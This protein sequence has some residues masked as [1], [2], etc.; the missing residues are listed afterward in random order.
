MKKVLKTISIALILYSF[1]LSFYGCNSFTRPPSKEA[2]T[3]V[4]LFSNTDFNN[5]GL[6]PQK[7]FIKKDLSG[8]IAFSVQGKEED[9]TDV[10]INAV[11]EVNKKAFSEGNYQ[12]GYRVIFVQEKFITQAGDNVSV[13]VEFTNINHLKGEVEIMTVEKYLEKNSSD[14][15]NNRFT[16]V[17]SE[18]QVSIVMI[19]DKESHYIAVLNGIVNQAEIVVEGCIVTAYYTENEGEHTITTRNSIK[20]ST[21]NYKFVYVEDGMPIWLLIATIVAGASFITALT[22]KIIK[23][24]KR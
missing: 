17:K 5:I 9:L 6:V 1:T 13:I 14:D 11:E 15:N 21:G 3:A 7:L 8:H 16:D 18:G 20:S 10:I 12:S 23:D 22:V 4:K 2:D 19:N 24:K